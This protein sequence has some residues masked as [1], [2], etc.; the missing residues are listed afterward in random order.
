MKRVVYVLLVGAAFAVGRYTAPRTVG[1]S[2]MTVFRDTLVRVDT[3][4]IVSPE[5]VAERTLPSRLEP[6]IT[7]DRDT[8]YV[9]V[10]VVQR[11]YEGED[12]RAWVSGWQPSLDSLVLTRPVTTDTVRERQSAPRLSFG[13]QAGYGLT[14]AGLQPYLG[15]GLTI[16]L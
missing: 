2:Q 13:L 3:V 10:P 15:L 9:E 7:P 5:P 12:Y 11:L 14:P 1:S 4:K 8:V 16:R 6:M